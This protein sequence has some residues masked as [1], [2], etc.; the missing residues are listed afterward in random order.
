[1][2]AA[3]PVNTSEQ[4][5]LILRTLRQRGPLTRRQMADLTGY[6][7]SL[8]RQLTEPLA[9]FNFIMTTGST[10]ADLP[11]RPSQLWSLA[12]DACRALGLDVS[13]RATRIV[14]LDAAGQV[15]YQAELPPQQPNTP[16]EMM[17][18]LAEIVETT[19]ASLGLNSAAL[20]GLGVAFGGF[21]D[22]KQGVSL[23]AI[24]IPHAQSLPLQEY[25]AGRL[26]MPVI[27]DDRSRAMALAEAR[28]GAARDGRDCICVNVSSGIG[29]GVILDGALYRGALG[30][31]GELGHIP[32][33]IGGSPCRCGGQGCLETV[34]SG[35]AIEMRARELMKQ[36]TATLLHS[37]CDDP[38][39]LTIGLIVEAA[40]R[41]DAVALA[42]ME[43]AGQW[44]GLG[45]ATLINLYSCDQI[46]LTGSVMQ[47]NS[48]LLEIIRREAQRYL[49][50]PIRERVRLSLT[51]LDALASAIGAA[52]FILDAEFDHGFARRLLPLEGVG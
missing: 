23:D 17:T 22:F 13:S 2:R 33:M 15:Q 27:L 12:P 32:V 47:G 7:V 5:A 28:Y 31:A 1:M 46:V 40:R 25:L 41:G 49:I 38:A 11:G 45:L 29:T 43:H 24:D 19:L 18:S 9:D 35:T 39:R 14:L 52:T 48:I 34:A 4:Q 44:L 37:L 3:D 50:R 10:P 21:V 26:G 8:V 16:A 20:R 42:L 6:S 30:L 51:E 36:G